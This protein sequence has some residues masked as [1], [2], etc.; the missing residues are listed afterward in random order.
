MQDD[1]SQ[2]N[3]VS[4]PVGNGNPDPT[5]LPNQTPLTEP[6]V[7]DQ[8]FATQGNNLDSFIGTGLTTD[9]PSST[10]TTSSFSD[11]ATSAPD[12]SKPVNTIEPAPESVA[13][14]S[15]FTAQPQM[16]LQPQP[17]DIPVIQPTVQLE[18]SGSYVNNT[19]TPNAETISDIP[20]S[21]VQQPA[22]PQPEMPKPQEPISTPAPETVFA[23]AAPPVDIKLKSQ[24]ENTGMLN[25]LDDILPPTEP[26]IMQPT[27]QPEP[28][29]LP[30]AAAMPE[31]NSTVIQPQ[32]V[33]EVYNL[34]P[35]QVEIPNNVVS[36]SF[37]I[38]PAEPEMVPVQTFQTPN[39][40]QP[41]PMETQQ[42]A[43]A[44][45]SDVKTNT[46]AKKNVVLIK[47]IKFGLWFLIL[48]LGIIAVVLGMY[49]AK[50]FN[51]P[52]LDQIFKQ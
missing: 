41:A 20:Q 3:P 15:E 21:E 27:I 33:S 50:V 17:Q 36:E 1:S 51:L 5:Q 25:V 30:F 28:S 14:T 18:S 23:S 11:L 9:A 49:F 19:Q 45:I 42:A 29:T 47:I 7:Q 10:V 12:A 4:T 48:V 40:V 46:P 24:H 22:I 39:Q 16:D 52:F 8:S 44:I 43:S 38:Q 37:P 32:N 2:V 6:V 13:N 34:T 35:S 26:P 31:E